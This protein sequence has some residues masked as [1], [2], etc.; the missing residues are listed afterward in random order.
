MIV[1]VDANIFVADLIQIG[2]IV[3]VVNFGMVY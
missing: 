3:G 2:A 1:S